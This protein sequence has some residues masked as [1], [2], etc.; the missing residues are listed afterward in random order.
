M[1][2]KT[3]FLLGLFILLSGSANLYAQVVK[4][5]HLIEALASSDQ[6][7]RDL[8]AEKLRENYKSA[9]KSKWTGLVSEIKKLVIL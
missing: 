1:K 2:S 3:T 4:T 8:D 9:P 5:E 6:L 7:T